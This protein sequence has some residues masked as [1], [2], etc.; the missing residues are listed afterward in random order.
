METDNRRP[1]AALINREWFEAARSIMSVQDLGI[2]LVRACEY[3]FGSETF[4]VG[5]DVQKAVFAMI[6]P[7]LDSDIA[8][9][10]ERC[11]RNAANARSQRQRVAASGSEWKQI[12][13]QLQLQ[14]QLQPQ[15]QLHL[16]LRQRMKRG[17]DG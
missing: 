8:K 12:Q 4:D 11:A 15:L 5:G 14:L 6:K 9:Y 17:R 1:N 3:V 16:Y 10:N 13:L 2:V 7:A